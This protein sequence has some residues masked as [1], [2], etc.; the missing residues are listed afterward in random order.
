[1]KRFSIVAMLFAGVAIFSVSA[2]AL[3]V[4]TV[5]RTIPAGTKIHCVL[6]QNVDSRTLTAGTGFLLRIDDPQLPALD[7]G[8]I[9]G[10]VTGVEQ[11]HG[12]E[13]ARIGFVLTNIRLRNGQRTG[14]HAEVLAE[15]VTQVDMAAVKR[16]RDK[17]LLPRLPVGTVTPGPV[18]FAIILRE[19]S[20]PS[21]TPPP[22]A[23]DGGYVYAAKSNEN[24][25]IAAGTPVTIKLTSNLALP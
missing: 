2:A 24:I 25:V 5:S 21:V 7:G 9:K 17:F 8:W 4:T 6:A 13:R 3:A 19:G 15:N 11:P 18:M 20:K 12:L 23:A 1:M 22:A 10:H 14:I 16:E